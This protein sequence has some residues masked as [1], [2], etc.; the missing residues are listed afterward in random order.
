MATRIAATRCDDI[1]RHKSIAQ[2]GAGV[3]RSRCGSRRNI[4]VHP[5]PHGVVFKVIHVEK[6]GYKS[7]SRTSKT[8]SLFGTLTRPS[9]NKTGSILSRIKYSA[10]DSR[11][12]AP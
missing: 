4:Y 8:S 10:C 2:S 6:L 9:K 1:D 12:M 3:S 5:R 7:Y 11:L